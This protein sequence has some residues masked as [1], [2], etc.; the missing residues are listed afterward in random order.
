MLQLHVVWFMRMNSLANSIGRSSFYSSGTWFIRGVWL[1]NRWNNWIT[2]K[3]FI[4][5]SCMYEKCRASFDLG[6]RCASVI[7]NHHS[8]SRYVGIAL[9]SRVNNTCFSLTVATT[10]NYCAMNRILINAEHQ[11]KPKNRE[12]EWVYDWNWILTRCV[13]A[14]QF[15]WRKQLFVEKWK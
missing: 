12:S 13:V 15:R 8:R 3:A 1:G 10:I 6:A 2:A 14:V 5:S 9:V 4:Q 11:E 7:S